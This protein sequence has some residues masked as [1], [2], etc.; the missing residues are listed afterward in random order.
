LG[1]DIVFKSYAAAHGVTPQNFYDLKDWLK[2]T[3][4]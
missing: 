1:I 4:K 2:E 3:K